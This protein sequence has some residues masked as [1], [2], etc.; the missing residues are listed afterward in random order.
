[1]LSPTWIRVFTHRASCYHPPTMAKR[2]ESAL[3]DKDLGNRPE[4]VTL[5]ITLF[6]SL[7]RCGQAQAEAS[8]YHPPKTCATVQIR[9]MG[10][11]QGKVIGPA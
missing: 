9:R 7:G 4:S 8:C 5:S 6:N 11:A 10:R 1:M 2:A 3:R